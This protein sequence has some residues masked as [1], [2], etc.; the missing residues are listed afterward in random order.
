LEQVRVLATGQAEDELADEIR[1]ALGDWYTDVRF[2][3]RSSGTDFAIE[4]RI[5]SELPMYP[6]Q[7]DVTWEYGPDES[8]AVYGFP[9][10][11]GDGERME[12]RILS[13]YDSGWLAL[14]GNDG[15]FELTDEVAELLADIG[16]WSELGTALYFVDL[17]RYDNHVVESIPALGCY[18][19]SGGTISAASYEGEDVWLVECTLGRDLP[20]S[21]SLGCI[22]SITMRAVVSQSSG[23]PLLG[24]YTASLPAAFGSPDSSA[25]PSSQSVQWSA[26]T[27]LVYSNEA[28]EFPQPEPVLSA[29]DLEEELQRRQSPSTEETPSAEALLD[30]ALDWAE[31]ADE[32]HLRYIRVSSASSGV[33]DVRRSRSQGVIEWSGPGA[34]RFD[35]RSLWNRDGYWVGYVN[36]DGETIWEQREPS[37]GGD[38]GRTIEERLAEPDPLDIERLRP[39][40]GI[41]RVTRVGSPSDTP[42]YELSIDSAELGPGDAMFAEFAA[43]LD[44]DDQIDAIGH[45][46]TGLII[47]ADSGRLIRQNTRYSFH[48]NQAD[49]RVLNSVCLISTGPLML[50]NPSSETTEQQGEER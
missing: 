24:E 3:I 13:W 28:A 33:S 25:E 23:A 11:S 22:E 9:G 43:L 41:A 30:L 16:P 34:Y 18:T 31:H 12:L 7:I 46:H 48:S 40:L 50:P 5:V 35:S 8:L 21:A 39:L 17:L 32:L 14:S 49:V 4:S 1:D 42:L 6:G 19:S 15:W 20:N 27:R 2:S 10:P 36:E 44:V 38:D 47:F 26:S 37:A 29:A 45:Y